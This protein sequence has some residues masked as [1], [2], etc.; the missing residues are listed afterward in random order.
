[1]AKGAFPQGADEAPARCMWV[2]FHVQ[3]ESVGVNINVLGQQFYL[4]PLCFSLP[5]YAQFVDIDLGIF[6]NIN[7][8]RMM[9]INRMTRIHEGDGSFE[10]LTKI[11]K[12]IVLVHVAGTGNVRFPQ[13]EAWVSQ[14]A[15][16]A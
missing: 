15:T 2:P 11:S 6:R 1:M 3:A 9:F 14:C 12:G 16:G 8:F 7:N 4:L 10:T 13:I 5:E